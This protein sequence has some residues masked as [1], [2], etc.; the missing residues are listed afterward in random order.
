M[1]TLILLLFLSLLS[2]STRSQPEYSLDIAEGSKYAFTPCY[3][4]DISLSLTDDCIPDDS[5]LVTT[6]NGTITGSH[7]RYQVTPAHSGT[8]KFSILA[9]NSM[10]IKKTDSLL[11]RVNIQPVEAQFNG[12]TRGRLRKS[13]ICINPAPQI[14]PTCCGM[15]RYTTDSFTV[16]VLRKKAI[17]YRN[18]VRKQDSILNNKTYRFFSTLKN[19][20]EVIFK[21]IHFTDDCERLDH[22][23]SGQLL[24]TV[25]NA[26]NYTADMK[27]ETRGVMDPVTGIETND[28]V[29]R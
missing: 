12:Q 29:V 7:G 24:F 5:L 14:I 27:L 11:F 22:L 23:Y 19:G 26:E 17:I 2:H 1:K 21:K 25:T 6:D 8:I 20:D 3:S 18:M 9:K 16:I 10:Q 15:E 28:K 4:T 13:A